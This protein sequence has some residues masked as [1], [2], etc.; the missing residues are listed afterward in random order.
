MRRARVHRLGRSPY[1]NYVE[2]EAVDAELVRARRLYRELRSCTA[3][4]AVSRGLQCARALA[5]E[6]RFEAILHPHARAVFQHIVRP[7][8]ACSCL[9]VGFD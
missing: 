3:Q 8:L 2:A 1:S 6:P 9:W 5:T 7:N 4:G